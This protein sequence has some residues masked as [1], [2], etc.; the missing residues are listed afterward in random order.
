MDLPKYC[1]LISSPQSLLRM[2][3][4]DCTKK[5]EKVKVGKVCF[6]GVDENLS[7]Y[8]LETIFSLK[9]ELKTHE[10]SFKRS[11][12]VN[13]WNVKYTR[14]YSYTI[15][16]KNSKPNSALR[17]CLHI[18]STLGVKTKNRVES[19]SPC[20]PKRYRN[21]VKRCWRLGVE[22]RQSEISRGEGG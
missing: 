1:N 21:S 13:C 7:Y 2:F 3:S 14:F 9:N 19:C 17:N 10:W 12:L 16:P 20:I 4:L 18:R 15:N 6:S 5:R 8:F 11:R 22:G